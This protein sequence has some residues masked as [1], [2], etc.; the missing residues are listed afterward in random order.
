MHCMTIYCLLVPIAYGS[1]CYK[2]SCWKVSVGCDVF[3]SV[4]RRAQQN[5]ASGYDSIHLSRNGPYSS[6][7]GPCRS[8]CPFQDSDISRSYGRYYKKFEIKCNSPW[9]RNLTRTSYPKARKRLGSPVVFITAVPKSH[10]YSTK[11]GYR[12]PELS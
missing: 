6:S 8:G 12:L 11:K 7:F 9:R 2:P 1:L 4:E 3:M 5:T 10:A